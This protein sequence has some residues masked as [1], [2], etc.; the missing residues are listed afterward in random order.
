MA[1][2]G[3]SPRSKLDFLYRDVLGEVTSLVERL[4]AVSAELGAVAKARATEGTAE[5]LARAAGAS[6]AKVRTEFE[7][8]AE[9]ACQRL[10]LVVHETARAV[11]EIQG[12]RRRDYVIWGAAYLGASLLGGAV[13][14]LLLRMP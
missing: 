13:A 4:E 5:A 8:S 2:S 6:A 11:S 7:R 10:G 1:D 3:D 12:A 9:I 14:A